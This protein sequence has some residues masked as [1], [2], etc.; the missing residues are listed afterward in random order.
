MAAVKS[1]LGRIPCPNGCGHTV[2]LKENEAGT[3]TVACEEC[4]MSAF[5]KKGTAAA[6]RWRAALPKAPET[7]PAAAPVPAPV[8][9]V[10]KAP[11]KR[12]GFSLSGLK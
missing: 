4:D 3:L 6:A 5:A 9:V 1:K 7:A 2:V 10:P 12:S 11:E 8:A